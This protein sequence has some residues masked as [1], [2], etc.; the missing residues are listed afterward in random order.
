MRL[1]GESQYQIT[2]TS[3]EL[4][5]VLAVLHGGTVAEEDAPILEHVRAALRDGLADAL[6]AEHLRFFE[7]P[8]AR[9]PRPL[10][11]VHAPPEPAPEP[12]PVELP[13]HPH[14]DDPAP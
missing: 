3:H 14:P 2:L 9:P 10:R 13:P 7:P 11:P 1:V 8:P 5:V 12:T 4:R 6:R